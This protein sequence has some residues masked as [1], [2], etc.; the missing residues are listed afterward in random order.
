MLSSDH[1][2]GIS[3]SHSIAGRGEKTLGLI[4]TQVLLRLWDA[5]HQ[6]LKFL[7]GAKPFRGLSLH[8]PKHECPP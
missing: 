5:A 8:L 4:R 3:L 1:S 2:L 6:V 7:W